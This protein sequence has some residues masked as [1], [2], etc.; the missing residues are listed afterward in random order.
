M[1][2]ARL[3]LRGLRFHTA[4]HAAVRL[5][6]ETRI[7]LEKTVIS[8]DE[9]LMSHPPRPDRTATRRRAGNEPEDRTIEELTGE[10]SGRPQRDK[11]NRRQ[12]SVSCF[13]CK[14]SWSSCRTAGH[15]SQGSDF[16]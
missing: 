10:A 13:A 15:G 12:Y 1:L 4:E 6:E 7:S 2:Q 8:S 11:E 5:P 9:E 14:A 3:N 16:V